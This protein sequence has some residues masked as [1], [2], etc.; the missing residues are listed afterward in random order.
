[1]LVGSISGFRVAIA[2]IY[3]PN[4]PSP[5]FFANVQTMLLEVQGLPLIMEGDFN[6]ILDTCLDRSQPEIMRE[7]LQMLIS[8]FGLVDIWRLV[9]PQ[10]SEFTFRSGPHHTRTRIDYFLVSK[11][12]VNLVWGCDI[13]AR[14]LVS[15]HAPV[16]LSLWCLEDLGRRGRW[17]LNVALP[18]SSPLKEEIE[19]IIKEFLELN[20]GSVATTATL[21]D[22]GKAY[23][24]GRIIAISFSVKKERAQ[25]VRELEELVEELERRESQGDRDEGLQELLE[26]K[27]ELN[28]IY[29]SLVQQ[30]EVRKW[31]PAIRIESG[32]L[33][34]DPRE[35]SG[36]FLSFYEQL[37][38]SD[39]SPDLRAYDKFLA[40][41]GTPRLSQ[42][43][44]ELLDTPITAA[45]VHSAIQ[46]MQQGKSPGDD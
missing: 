38:S 45:E 8:Q 29:L 12:L 37:Y 10:A 28:S 3:T 9:N 16:G 27:F 17:R 18:K 2:N 31:I 42:R 36:A 23:L 7:S 1:I 14:V 32:D 46:S 19:Q 30:R 40:E 21:W 13:G 26:A 43:E 6:Q 34:T 41:V 22:A 24:R 39:G 15:D 25:R 11:S 33:V 44:R 5:P 20:V 35:I 4:D